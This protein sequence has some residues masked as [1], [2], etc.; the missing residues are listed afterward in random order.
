MRF[1]LNKLYFP[2]Y[3]H[4][5]LNKG[6]LMR[7]C[8]CFITR[9]CTGAVQLH[10]TGLFLLCGM[11][12][13]SACVPRVLQEEKP[14]I[15]DAART[16]ADIIKQPVINIIYLPWKYRTLAD[17]VDL[18]VE[19]PR[20]KLTLGFPH[21]YLYLKDTDTEEYR[22]LLSLI[23]GGRVELAM[24]LPKEPVLPLIAHTDDAKDL[25]GEHGALPVPPFS[26]P[27]DIRQQIAD[28]REAFFKRWGRFPG[29]F[30]PFG[31][32]LSPRSVKS[33]KNM[34]IEWCISGPSAQMDGIAYIDE[35]YPVLFFPDMEITQIIYHSDH[36]LGSRYLADKIAGII[37]AKKNKIIT[38]IFDEDHYKAVYNRRMIPLIGKVFQALQKGATDFVCMLPNELIRVDPAEMQRISLKKI[39]LSSW[40]HAD[41]SPFIGEDE[42]NTAWGLLAKVR[43]AVESYQN[44]GS[45]NLKRLTSAIDEIY[46]AEASIN[47]YTFGHD[48]DTIKD[49]DYERS[50]LAGLINIYRMMGQ[51]PPEELYH[52]LKGISGYSGIVLGVADTH[53]ELGPGYVRWTDAV[54]DDH[55]SGD[56]EYPIP[57]DEYPP[58][59]YDLRDFL[60]KYDDV[61]IVFELSFGAMDDILQTPFG[62]DLP[63]IDIYMDLNHRKGAGSTGGLPGR[64]FRIAA[65]D[66]WEYCIS[67]NGWGAQLYRHRS[68]SGFMETKADVTISTLPEEHLVSITLSRQSIRGNPLNWGYVVVIMGNERDNS[69][70]P[71]RPLPV[72]SNPKR[73]H[74]FRGTWAGFAPPPVIDILTPQNKKQQA[75]LEVY[76]KQIPITLPALRVKE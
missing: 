13:I 48:Y 47:F 41:L 23:E 10:Y 22:K 8:I 61:N 69:A 24:R 68:S 16:K 74:V 75:L 7:R 57:E 3:M 50:F 20:V 25:L 45:A 53:M 12:F 11:L 59:S 30:V 21:K 39:P 70:L 38:L 51:E 67:A 65:K 14:A 42:E 15:V 36:L 27:G 32:W 1:I 52:P 28:E 44:S 49:N 62:C 76:K 40:Q 33:L 4:D 37:R 55:G 2:R 46:E 6:F 29:G 18:V 71:P 43:E 64:D 35:K 60:V 56:I 19:N 63:L 17:I 26:W 31:G 9:P 5:T 73:E 72:V 54:G 34:D 66:A 58:G